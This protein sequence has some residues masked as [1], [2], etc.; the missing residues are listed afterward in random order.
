[1]QEP[2]LHVEL[3]TWQGAHG[4]SLPLTDTRGLVITVPCT[5]PEMKANL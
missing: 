1:M 5:S 4:V 2:K 3:G